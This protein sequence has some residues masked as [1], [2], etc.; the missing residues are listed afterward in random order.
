MVT[1]QVFYNDNQIEDLT[2]RTLDTLLRNETWR[3][4]VLLIQGY[5]P[6]KSTLKGFYSQE[7]QVRYILHSLL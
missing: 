3:L 2:L 4:Q 7:P 6:S 1:I 5:I